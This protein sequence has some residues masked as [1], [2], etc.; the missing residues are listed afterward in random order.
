MNIRRFVLALLLSFII[1]LV[2]TVAYVFAPI[3][4]ALA[5]SRFAVPDTAGI[6]AVVGGASMRGLLLTE[7]IVLAI[8]LFI[9]SRRRTA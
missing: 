6:A 5:K 8:L 4:V 2:L 3:V 9:L 7:A 1:T